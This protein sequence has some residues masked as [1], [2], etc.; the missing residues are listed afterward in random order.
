MTLLDD[1]RQAE[2]EEFNQKILK[3]MSARGLQEEHLSL[4]TGQESLAE[5]QEIII[6]LSERCPAGDNHHFCPFRL[7]GG[8]SH[9]SLT[10]LVNEMNKATCME[11]FDQERICRT[12]AE[13]SKRNQ[14]SSSADESPQAEAR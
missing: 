10:C 7:L 12:Q 1:P 14:V 9:A 11:L 2:V 13:F 8:L 4:L 3:R 5:L 6:R